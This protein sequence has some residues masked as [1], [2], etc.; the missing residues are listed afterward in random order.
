MG[1]KVRQMRSILKGVLGLTQQ[2][3]GNDRNCWLGHDQLCFSGGLLTQR[4]KNLP[5]LGVAAV[6]A[7]L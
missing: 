1:Y 2:Q 5:V 4:L 7:S 3:P 6:T